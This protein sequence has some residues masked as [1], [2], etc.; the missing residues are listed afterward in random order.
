MRTGVRVD[1]DEDEEEAS[2]E[3]DPSAVFAVSFPSFPRTAS[4]AFFL[5]ALPMP[6]NCACA[7]NGATAISAR[8][9][10]ILKKYF[11]CIDNLLM[12]EQNGDGQF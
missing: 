12:G 2:L 6:P 11:D 5:I 9:R 10:P 8:E 1:E 4:T 3:E 7:G